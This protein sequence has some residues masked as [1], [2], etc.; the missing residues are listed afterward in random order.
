MIP[1]QII[2][3]FCN[4]IIEQILIAYLQIFLKI[5]LQTHRKYFLISLTTQ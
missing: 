4:L 3:T 5:L 1:E 2:Q